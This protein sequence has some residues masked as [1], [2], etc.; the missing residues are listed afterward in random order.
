MCFEKAVC[1]SDINH[2]INI[3]KSVDVNHHFTLHGHLHRLRWENQYNETLV[4]V[5]INLI[6]K[7]KTN[8]IFD[9]NVKSVL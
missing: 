8:S 4:S 7:T 9:T 1:I 2:W 5:K 6:E 3:R